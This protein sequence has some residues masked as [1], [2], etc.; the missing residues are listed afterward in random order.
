MISLRYGFASICYNGFVS[1]AGFSFRLHLEVA[2]ELDPGAGSHH[3][4][5]LAVHVVRGL[6]RHHEGQFSLVIDRDGL[7]RLSPGTL[8]L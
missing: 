7:L 5:G 4:V 3:V 2:L 1:G 6:L 8:V